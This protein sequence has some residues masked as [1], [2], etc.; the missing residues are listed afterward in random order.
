MP[1]TT[2]QS[3]H[4]RTHGRP[5]GEDANRGARPLFAAST[6]TALDSLSALAFWSAIGLPILYLPLL[7]TGLSNAGDLL[8]F[9]GLFTVHILA[10][11][12]GRSHRRE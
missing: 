4:D 8:V 10:L 11:L 7:V 9:L 1:D 12:A 5:S 6:R 3:L 2:D